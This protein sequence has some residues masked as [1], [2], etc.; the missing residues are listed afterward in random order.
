MTL[1]KPS[2]VPAPPVTALTLSPSGRELFAGSQAGVTVYGAESLERLETLS[3]AMDQVH[4]VRFTPD[5]KRFA[6]VGGDPAET[7]TVQWHDAADRRRLS[8]VVDGDDVFY[9]MDIAG[10]ASRWAVAGLDEFAYVFRSDSDSAEQRLAGHSG[11]VLGVCFLPGGTSLVTAGRDQTLRVWDISTGQTLRTLHNHTADVVALRLRP[12]G[13]GLPMVASASH[14]RTI[15]FWQPTIGRMVRFARLTARPLDIAW[16][17]DGTRL[18][19]ACDDGRAR[20]IDP[21]T[22]EVLETSRAVADWTAAVAVDGSRERG[23]LGGGDGRLHEI[24]WD[25]A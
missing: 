25:A 18:V 2:A 10:D 15:R 1:G 22:V 6:V 24:R 20:W 23:L 12:G 16:T 14:D 11:P 5:G 9:A 3:V 7:G 4:D 19:A 21:D 8:R 17:P 13:P